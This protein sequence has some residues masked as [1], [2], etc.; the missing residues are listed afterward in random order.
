MK[1]RRLLVFILLFALLLPGCGKKETDGTEE[2]GDAVEAVHRQNDETTTEEPETEPP[3]TAEPRPGDGKTIYLTFDDGPGVSTQHLLAILA[4]YDVKATF[5]VTNFRPDCRFL[6]ARE[7]REGHTVAVHSYTHDY[8]KI[9]ASTDAFWQ[10]Y[11]AM[12][13]II[14]A[15]TG[16]HATVMRFPGGTSN[17]I[18]KSYCSGI[19]TV[20]AQQ[21]LAKGISYVDW[22]VDSNDAGGASS[23]DEVLN[24]LKNSV[25]KMT[26]SVVLCHDI[27]PYT[28]EAMESF[29]PWALEEGYTFMPCTADSFVCRHKP[30]N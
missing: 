12:D 3:T 17:T 18:S 16:Q 1:L 26:N 11:N 23:S 14:F 8:K 10:D 5:F 25:S 13:D 4:Q 15:C 7:A 24:N 2:D 28:V 22:N 6:I 9:Y 19:M 27:K 29:I 21:M 30:Q 20:L